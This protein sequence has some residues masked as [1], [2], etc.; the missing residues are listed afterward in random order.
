M[1]ILASYHISPREPLHSLLMKSISKYQERLL[2]TI[3]FVP[4][5]TD[6]HEF[7]EET[8]K[9]KDLLKMNDALQVFLT[10]LADHIDFL[11]HF[12]MNKSHLFTEY[13]EEKLKEL[14]DK[15]SSRSQPRPPS[16]SFLSMI[17]GRQQ[18]DSITGM[19]VMVSLLWGVHMHVRISGCMYMYIRVYRDVSLYATVFQ[20]HVYS[21]H[22]ISAQLLR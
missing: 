1:G 2:K 14:E 13:L 6:N 11:V 7:F 19:S 17:P 21:S 22:R 12:V 4:E 18:P 20:L 8:L 5:E 16:M 10:P 3:V 15:V 9:M